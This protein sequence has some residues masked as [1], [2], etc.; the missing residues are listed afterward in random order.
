MFPYTSDQVGVTDGI[1]SFCPTVGVKCHGSI[2]TYAIDGTL[3][4]REKYGLSQVDDRSGYTHELPM[5]K[6]HTRGRS[7]FLL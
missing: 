7:L 6:I 3:Q 4:H 1:I 2:D 5:F